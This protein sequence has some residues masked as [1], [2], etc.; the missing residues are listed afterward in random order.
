MEQNQHIQNNSVID[1]DF[2]DENASEI[3]IRFIINEKSEK[4]P[5]TK[6]FCK[7]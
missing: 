1:K 3:L 7:T 4:F 2:I 5:C 6:L